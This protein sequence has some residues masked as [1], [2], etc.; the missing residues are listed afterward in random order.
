MSLE[1]DPTSDEKADQANILMTALQ[2]PEQKIQLTQAKNSEP[3]KQW[4]NRYILW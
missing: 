2:D 3:R 4:K 1:E